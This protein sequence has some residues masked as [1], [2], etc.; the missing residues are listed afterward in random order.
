[1]Q[2]REL[3]HYPP[4]MFQGPDRIGEALEVGER[5]SERKAGVPG[6]ARKCRQVKRREDQLQHKREDPVLQGLP[7]ANSP[8]YCGRPELCRHVRAGKHRGYLLHEPPA[9]RLHIAVDR[10]AHRMHGDPSDVS[11]KWTRQLTR[12]D[13][14]PSPGSPRDCISDDLDDIGRGAVSVI[15]YMVSMTERQ[16]PESASWKVRSIRNSTFPVEPIRTT[17]GQ[18]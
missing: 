10:E 9:S 2:R 12:I 3:S 17:F 1:M 11:A 7:G 6:V 5:I 16:V 8:L 14:H 13:E 4:Y 18:F 15:L